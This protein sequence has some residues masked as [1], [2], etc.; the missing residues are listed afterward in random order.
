MSDEG[1]TITS[2]TLRK[3]ALLTSRRMDDYKMLGY[4]DEMGTDD[5]EMQEDAIDDSDEYRE[6]VPKRKKKSRDP[7][8]G[9]V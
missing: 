8:F 2:T 9:E 7:T 3:S 4:E 1:P 6:P 5:H